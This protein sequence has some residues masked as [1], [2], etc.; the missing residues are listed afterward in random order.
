MGCALKK[1]KQKKHKLGKN[2]NIFVIRWFGVP[3]NASCIMQVLG[4]KN[5][6]DE[7]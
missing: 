5:L 6:V 2:F 1:K 3:H 7:D 4:P